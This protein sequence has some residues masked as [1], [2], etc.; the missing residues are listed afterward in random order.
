MLA[1]LSALL[2]VLA[3]AVMLMGAHLALRTLMQA[4]REPQRRARWVQWAAA[5]AALG[6]GVWAA[7]L[8]GLSSQSLD[9]P[10][11]FRALGLLAA[12]L[13]AALPAA[14]ALA[15]LLRWLR[16]AAVLAAGGLIACGALL[17]QVLLVQAAGTS[18]GLHWRYDALAIAVPVATSGCIA[19]LWVAFLSAGSTAVGGD[20]GA[21][22]GSRSGTRRR[23]RG[24]RRAAAAMVAVALI[25]SQE[26][27]MASA[28]MAGQKA[29]AY[30]HQVPADVA[31]VVAGLLVPLLL[32]MALLVQRLRRR[33]LGGQTPQQRSSRRRVRSRR[34]P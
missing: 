5:S 19:G 34:G 7:M 30:A 32:G 8:L 33:P 22:S 15:L 23:R 17:A 9:Y 18:P 26:L 2:W 14:L 21:G 24:W 25:G 27:V 12:W 3:A 11:G 10:L 1:D 13:G 28:G 31:C 6:T 4:G 20:S 16:P 29:S